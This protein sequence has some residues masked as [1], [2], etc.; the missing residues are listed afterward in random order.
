LNPGFASVLCKNTTLRPFAD[1]RTNPL[2]V[3][4][5][6]P[7]LFRAEKLYAN[8][9]M[10]VHIGALYVGMYVQALVVLSILLS[11]YAQNKR[12]R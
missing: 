11:L 1:L 9:Q 5:V 12:S 3:K 10:D 4:Y 7:Y 6:A 2:I 8:T